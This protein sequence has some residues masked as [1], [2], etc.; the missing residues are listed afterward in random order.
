MIFVRALWA[1]ALLGPIAAFAP[2]A[3]GGRVAASRSN[4]QEHL[5]VGAFA[6][7][8]TELAAEGSG[9]GPVWHTNLSRNGPE[10]LGTKRASGDGRRL[11]GGRR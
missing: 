9:A 6:M 11:R 10:Q 7:L 1:M 2:A 5:A 8:V 4:S 3:C